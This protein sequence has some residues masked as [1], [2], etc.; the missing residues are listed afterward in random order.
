MKSVLG[1]LLVVATLAASVLVVPG[2]ASA[3][4]SFTIVRDNYGVPHVYASTVRALFYGNGY[5]V[6]QDRL[7]QADVIRR[8]GTGTLA[9]VL[10]PDY[11]GMDLSMRQ[12]T[13]GP[14]ARATVFDQL[15]PRTKVAFHAFVDGINRW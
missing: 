11:A 9:A 1:R 13:G 3:E 5:A 7:F 2:T 15:P 14:A 6:G 8:L 12:Y 4:S 10:G